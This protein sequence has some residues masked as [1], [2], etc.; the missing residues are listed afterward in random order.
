MLSHGTIRAMESEAAA[1]AAMNHREPLSVWP[2]SV[3]EDLRGIPFLGDYCPAGW[4]MAERSEFT[5]LGFKGSSGWSGPEFTFWVDSSGCGAEGEMALTQRQF[6]D[7]VSQLLR[8]VEH[9]D[10]L[11]RPPMVL[12][13]AVREVGQFQVYVGVYVKDPDAVG[14]DAWIAREA[15]GL[16][17]PGPCCDRCGEDGDGDG[18]ELAYVN[19]ETGEAFCV[20]CAPPEAIESA[21]V[22]SSREFNS[23]PMG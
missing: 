22:I 9:R 12:G 2:Q 15:S 21:P 4:R 20:G 18:L 11:R 1:D 13:F 3:A 14:S 16:D 6:V 7:R 8:A 10:G 23:W 17:G 19:A 5:E